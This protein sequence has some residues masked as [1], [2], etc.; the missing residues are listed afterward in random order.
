MLKIFEASGQAQLLRA[1]GNRQFSS[2]L[3]AGWDH[4]VK[5]LLRAAHVAPRHVSKEHPYS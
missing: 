5:R 4:I 3:A 2:V 1:E